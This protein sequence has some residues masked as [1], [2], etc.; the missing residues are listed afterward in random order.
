[1]KKTYKKCCICGKAARRWSD[2]CQSCDDLEYER[3]LRNLGDA[4]NAPMMDRKYKHNGGI[5]MRYTN[6][7]K[8]QKGRINS[9]IKHLKNSDTHLRSFDNC[10]EMLDGKQVVVGIMTSAQDDRE[11][12]SAL[13]SAGFYESWSKI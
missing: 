5:K 13:K 4:E 1:L 12:V 7:P 2:Y 10:F 8:T 6:C 11:L 3:Y 9:A